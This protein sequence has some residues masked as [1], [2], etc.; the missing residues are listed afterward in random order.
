MGA[1]Y[2]HLL[3]Q[4]AA[5]IYQ[6][7]V[8]QRRMFTDLLQAVQVI[9]L[10]FTLGSMAYLGVA[11]ACVALFRRRRRDAAAEQPPVTILKPIYGLD[12]GLYE[13]LRSFCD[14]DYPAY[15][16]VFGVRH[17]GDPA[18]GVIRRVIKEFPGRDLRLVIDDRVIGANLKVSTLANMFVVAKHDLLV[19]ADSDMRV[20]RDYL[21]TIV[22]PFQDPKVGG[23]TCL[24][25]GVPAAGLTSRMGSMHIN[26]WFLPSVLVAIAFRK[27]RFCF[28]ATM[29]VRRHVLDEIGGFEALASALADDYLLGD[30][31]T[32][33]GYDL[34]LSSYVVQN[35]V[36]EPSFKSLFHHQLRWARTVRSV[37][38]LGYAFS[39]LTEALTISL[40]YLL[41]SQ[42][43]P[44]GLAL[45]ACALVLSLSLHS[46][47]RSTL[48]IRGPDAP[49]LMPLMDLFSFAIWW[50][51]CFSRNIHWRDQE[52]TVHSGGELTCR[53]EGS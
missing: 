29:A 43:S 9:T 15:Q 24:Y 36:L 44:L 39:F 26:Y 28:G 12:H 37:R 14:Q 19:V 18:V 48:R 3:A 42:F 17:A 25:T 4:L 20:G 2:M 22:G 7:R 40:L 33:K 31:I 51:G 35:I 46:I 23:V 38:P 27:L 47:V 53:E 16:V 8:P 10:V 50:L 52:L 13:N 45:V 49:W 11:I 5:Y 32:R 1:K 41:A 30:L 21:K 34:R 6:I